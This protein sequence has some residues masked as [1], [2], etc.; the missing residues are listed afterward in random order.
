VNGVT[1][2]TFRIL[3]A[4]LDTVPSFLDLS[5]NDVPIG[6]IP[7][8]PPAECPANPVEA[9]FTDPTVLALV[10]L[11]TC[12]RF[13]VDLRTGGSAIR[14]GIVQIVIGTVDGPLTVCA[15]DGTLG[16]TAPTCNDRR[17]CQPP[18]ASIRVASVLG[19]LNC[20]VCGD[21]IVDPGEECDDG[22]TVSGDGCSADCR[23]EDLDHDGV[24]DL[25]DR[26]LDTR[27]PEGVPTRYLGF[28][29]YAIVT[30]ARTRDGLA[31][32]DTVTFW[33]HPG[34]PVTTADTGGCSCEQIL[35]VLGAHRDETRLGCRGETIATWIRSIRG[36]PAG[37]ADR[38]RDQPGGHPVPN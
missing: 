20:S 1:S 18:R 19:L 15:F 14:L 23:L 17:L 7:A 27:I 37:P 4:D 5:I 11:S 10:H 28:E 33:R 13:G 8:S 3:D 22:N 24:A 21:H 36:V 32:F 25:E 30:G 6:S 26:C 31:I 9:T 12:N 38:P 16:N 35:S 34:R 2:I 29:R